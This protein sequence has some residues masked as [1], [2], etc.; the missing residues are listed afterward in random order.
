MNTF[1]N[2]RRNAEAYRQRHSTLETALWR[3]EDKVIPAYVV[4]ITH[5][6]LQHGV[7]YDLY[8]MITAAELYGVLRSNSIEHVLFAQTSPIIGCACAFHS[9]YFVIDAS[10]HHLLLD[11]YLRGLPPEKTDWKKE[12]F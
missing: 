5:P 7:E 3:L 2:I 11:Y 8:K 12:G 9:H 1:T 4:P 10:E 6:T